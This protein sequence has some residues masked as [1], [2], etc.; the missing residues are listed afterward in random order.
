MINV[1]PEISISAALKISGR[2]QSQ[3]AKLMGVTRSAVNDWKMR[4]G[5]LP[6]LYAYRFEKM[7]S[8]YF[9]Q[10]PGEKS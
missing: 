8:E 9:Q 2:N 10:L 4:D 5:M 7:F 3:L 6:A 1:D